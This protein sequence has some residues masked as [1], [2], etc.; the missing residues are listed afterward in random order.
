MLSASRRHT[1]A[2]EYQII[3]EQTPEKPKFQVLSIK[4]ISNN[5][6]DPSKP[7]R[8]RL[9]LSDG[10]KKQPSAMLATQLN[11]FI[12]NNEVV[13]NGVIQLD[14]YICNAVSG[15]K[16]II[17]LGVTVISGAV[18]PIGDPSQVSKDEQAASAAPAAAAPVPAASKPPSNNPFTRCARWTL[19]ALLALLTLLALLAVLVGV[20]YPS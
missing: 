12:T 4:K 6:A 17:I 11:H 8:Y 2:H 10:V 9:C 20:A 18:D 14:R 3:Q 16:I 5:G 19:L 7:E 15:I 1:Y 13:Q